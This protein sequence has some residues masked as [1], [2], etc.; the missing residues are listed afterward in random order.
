VAINIPDSPSI[1]CGIDYINHK[2]IIERITAMGGMPS[3]RGVEW[4]GRFDEQSH[5]RFQE[6]FER[7]PR[8]ED[9]KMAYEPEPAPIIEAVKPIPATCSDCGLVN[10][11]PTETAHG[12]KVCKAK[13]AEND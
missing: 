6:A 10:V 11:C 8:D 7:I 12:S 13:L 9:G 5:K 4:K 1:Y 3:A 2:S